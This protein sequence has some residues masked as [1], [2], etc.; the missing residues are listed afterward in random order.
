MPKYSYKCRECEYSFDAYHSMKTRLKDCTEC[1]K[2]DSLEKVLSDFFI[3]STDSPHV[4]NVVNRSIEEFRRDLK[5]EKH[6][7]TKQ[8]YKDD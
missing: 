1:E 3:H 4:G 8:E 6:R 7:L 2:V 5:E